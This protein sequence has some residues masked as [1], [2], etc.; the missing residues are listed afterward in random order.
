MV[1]FRCHSVGSVAEEK[2][3]RPFTSSEVW[4]PAG[5][6]LLFFSLLSL[7]SSSSSSISPSVLYP[8]NSFSL[9]QK[10]NTFCPHLSLL[11]RWFSF[12]LFNFVRSTSRKVSS[13]F[14]MFLSSLFPWRA[15]SSCSA[16]SRRSGWIFHGEGFLHLS[17]L[18]SKLAERN[19]SSVVSSSPFLK[20]IKRWPS[21]SGGQSKNTARW[22]EGERQP[23][24]RGQSLS[25]G[26]FVSSSNR[27]CCRKDWPLFFINTIESKEAH[28][29]QRE[30]SDFIEV[31][32]K[33][34]NLFT[35]SKYF[36]K[37][38]YQAVACISV[39]FCYQKAS[40]CLMEKYL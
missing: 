16:C 17:S 11:S 34:S 32:W 5:D 31:N 7:S 27:T 23:L 26:R 4:K 12:V 30:H 25:F 14:K 8:I 2:L 13:Y 6:N 40:V 10:I 38:F 22:G 9:S 33:T 35:K 28:K 36:H 3:S 20:Q 39:A 15:A 24:S 29:Q 37:N 1:Y 18:E 21:I 19:D